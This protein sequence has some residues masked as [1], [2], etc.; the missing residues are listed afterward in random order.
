MIKKDDQSKKWWFFIKIKII[1][2]RVLQFYFIYNLLF[3]SFCDSGVV[4]VI[5]KDVLVIY[6]EG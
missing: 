6:V 1:H 5:F 4:Y 3:F 2:H